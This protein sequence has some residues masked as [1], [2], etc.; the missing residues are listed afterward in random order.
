MGEKPILGFIGVGVMGGIA[1]TAVLLNTE[2]SAPNGDL[3]RTTAPL[4]RF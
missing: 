3:G 4:L 1:L 2:K